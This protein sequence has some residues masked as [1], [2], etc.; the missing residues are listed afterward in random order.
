MERTHLLEADRLGVLAEG[1]PGHVQA[2][3]ADQAG[4]LLVARDSAAPGALAVGA[5]VGKPDVLVGHGGVLWAEA[6]D[7]LRWND[8]EKV[9][10]VE[11]SS[12][13]LVE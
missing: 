9:A 1:L 5:W 7:I 2:I 4:L 3:L 13:E 12:R 8:E 6:R 10:C 11:G